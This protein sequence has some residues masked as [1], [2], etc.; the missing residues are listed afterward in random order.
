MRLG[1]CP[2]PRHLPLGPVLAPGSTHGQEEGGRRS[3]ALDPVI[4]WHLLTNECDDKDL[5]GDYFVKRDAVRERDRAVN[6][7]LSLG[8]KVT[9]EEA[10]VA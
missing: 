1:C 8:Y 5:G 10:Y 9:L 3:G 4:I 6:Q 7:L 2:Q